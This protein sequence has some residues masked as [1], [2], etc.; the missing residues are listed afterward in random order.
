MKL[1]LWRVDGWIGSTVIIAD[2]AFAKVIG[3]NFASAGVEIIPRE[4]PID[5]VLIVGY[6]DGAAD[7]TDA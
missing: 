2:D 7:N 3:L 4:L 5:F 6:Q 1:R